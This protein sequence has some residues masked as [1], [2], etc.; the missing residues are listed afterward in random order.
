VKT[1]SDVTKQRAW[2]DS[3]LLSAGFARYERKK[4]L[5]MAKPLS[6]DESPMTFAWPLETI[7]VE[8]PYIICYD[9][10]QGIL[11]A[12]NDYDCWPVRPDL[13]ERIYQAW[14]EPG[15]TPSPAV[16]HLM[17]LGCK[18]YFKTESIWAKK[19]DMPTL[20]QSM[21]SRQPVLIPEGQWLAIGAMGEPWY[22]DDETFRE[23]YN[24]GKP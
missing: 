3:E 23:R 11:P 15:W 22:L 12:L 24:A 17:R 8:V 1:L 10:G 7:V 6:A 21:E 19:L 5:V 2:T 9:P 20:V 13:F 14:D 18:P 4:Q 16:T